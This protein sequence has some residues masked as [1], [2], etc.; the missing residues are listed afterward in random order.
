MCGIVGVLNK[1]PNQP[2]SSDLIR[3]MCS[4][5]KHRGPDD[6]GVL[7]DR[8][9]GIGMRRLTVIDVE[10]G[11]QPQQNEDGS[12]HIV[13]NGEIYNYPELRKACQD[14]G[15]LFATNSDTETI[16]H[17]F[18]DK[19]KDCVAPLNGMF[20]FAVFDTRSR[21]VTLA[22]DRL[23][24]KPLYYADT[25][26]SL[27][28]GSEIKSLLVYPEVSRE[29]DPIGLDHYLTY[30]YVPEPRTIFKQI[31]KLPPGHLLT[32]QDN[33]IEIQSY[34]GLS[35]TDQ[36]GRSETDLA[37]ELLQRLQ[38]A[39]QMQMISDVPLGALLSGGID[40]SAIVGMMSKIS[41]QPV[42]TFSIGFEERSYSELEHARTIAQSFNTEHRELVVRPDVQELFDRVVGHFDEPF[43]D[44]SAI[45]TYLVSQ[46]AREHVTVALSGTGADELFAGYERY[47]AIPLS[48]AY[49]R[50]PQPIRSAVNYASQRLPTG[51]EKKSLTLRARRF[52]ESASSPLLS[53]HRQVVGLFSPLDRSEL[54]TSDWFDRIQ[55]EE[56]DPL[57]ARYN[58]SDAR[59]DLN[60][61]LDVDTGTLLPGDYLVKDDRMSMAVSLELRVPFLDHTLVEFAA[62]LP[63]DMKLRRLTTKY[64]L[65]KSL[66]DL[67]PK[68]ILR[69]PKHG[70]EIPIARWIDEDLKEPVQDLLLSKRATERGLF[71]RHRINSLLKTH[72]SGQDNLSRQIWSLMALEV[73]F[74]RYVD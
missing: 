69:R 59:S 45:P 56:E 7:V 53:R 17:L 15:H 6:E 16:V 44:S 4:A 38:K 8:N 19:G 52:T 47:W 46:L 12:I 55:R 57:L 54:Y 39:V 24:I 22:R 10:G 73:W 51:R 11:K 66:E 61:L 26:K 36:G 64:L 50:I 23:G 13:Y 30:K 37:E 68:H 42:N 40:S 48:R 43:A 70:F 1:D 67:L 34:W 31:R 49:S 20:A 65:K 33:R 29:I 27:V 63:P 32:W 41:D 74:R 2:V 25:G 58:A 3:D 28:F 62:T 9:I 18:E 21:T 5:I 35:Y 14:N 60:R 72:A 71:H